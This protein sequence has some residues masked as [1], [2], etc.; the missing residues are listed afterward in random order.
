MR[1]KRQNN[2]KKKYWAR[3]EVIQNRIREASQVDQ[4]HQHVIY[5]AYKKDVEGLPLDNLAE[6]AIEGTVEFIGQSCLV[7][8]N[9]WYKGTEYRSAR[10]CNPTWLTIA[11]LA[12]EMINTTKDYCHI[13]LENISVVNET[14]ELKVMGF[15]MGS[16]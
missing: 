1:K 4:F 11:L 9:P 7:G 14:P 6:I 15:E 3:D 8:K 5:Q 12:N 13:Y 10:V 16:I 2:D